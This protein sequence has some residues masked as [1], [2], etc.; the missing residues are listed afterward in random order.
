MMTGAI[1]LLAALCSLAVTC[2]AT[3]PAAVETPVEEPVEQPAEPVAQP[4]KEP[5][6]GQEAAGLE[7]T[8]AAQGSFEVSEEVYRKT[9]EEIQEILAV[10]ADIIEAQDYDMWRA[11]LTPEYVARTS[12]EEYLA[13]VSEGPVLKKAGIRVRNLQEYFTYVVVPSRS[14][15][16]LDRLDFVDATHVKAIT[17]VNGQ[18][19]ILWSLVLSEGR[20]KIGIW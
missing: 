5:S 20:W 14:T 18:A 9:F 17:L 11:W 15:A 10:L 3:V 7:A 12:N 2:C 1:L 8:S 19:Y 16:K 13:H 6:A 4:V